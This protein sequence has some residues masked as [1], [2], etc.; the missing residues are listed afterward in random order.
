[1]EWWDEAGLWGATV[2]GAGSRMDGGL[3]VDGCSPCLYGV[4]RVGELGYLGGGWWEPEQIPI[5]KQG[6]QLD[7]FHGA[8]GR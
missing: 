7:F 4:P 8:A 1:M 2:L 3:G 6:K 5:G